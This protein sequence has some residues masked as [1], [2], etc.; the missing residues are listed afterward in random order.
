[1]DTKDLGLLKHILERLDTMNTNMVEIAKIQSS[2][3]EIL[4]EHIR[5]TLVLEEELARI[6]PVFTFG[7]VLFRLIGILATVVTLTGGLVVVV[8]KIQTLL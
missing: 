3:H 2:Q 7:A 1:M 6:K 8:L 4:K 5:R